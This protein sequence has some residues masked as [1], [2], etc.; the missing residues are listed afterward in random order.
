MTLNGLHA[1]IVEDEAILSILIED[2]LRDLGCEIVTVAARL[3]EAIEK[4]SALAIDFATL[5]INLAGRL[6]YPVAAIL[7][8]RKI[9]FVFVTGYGP[10]GLPAELR[11]VPV[12][13]KPFRQA[14]LADVLQ[15]MLR[16]G[17]GG[18]D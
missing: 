18:L 7:R 9:P 8:T 10:A 2:Y 11:D 14:K 13:V 6:S 16:P 3:D 4:A 15:A 17:A 12:L 1:L 5:D